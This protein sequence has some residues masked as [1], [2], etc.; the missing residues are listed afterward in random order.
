[1]EEEVILG[2]AVGQGAVVRA[3]HGL[4]EGEQ[5]RL[6][7]VDHGRRLA[8]PRQR[9]HRAQHVCANRAGHVV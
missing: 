9:R 3:V 2:R 4:V 8:V 6:A 1:M 5:H 7:G